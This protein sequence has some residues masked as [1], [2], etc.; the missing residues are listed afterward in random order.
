MTSYARSMASYARPTSAGVQ[1]CP[2]RRRRI[3]P[4]CVRVRVRAYVCA[5]SVRDTA[6]ERTRRSDVITIMDL[7]TTEPFSAA[8]EVTSK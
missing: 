4:A 6:A 2:S 3:A 5:Y 7:V 8:E 1:Y